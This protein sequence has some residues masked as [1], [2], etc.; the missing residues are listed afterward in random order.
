MSTRRSGLGRGLDAL[1]PS[2]Q[3]DEEGG[4]E[5]LLRVPVDAI[6]PNPRQP[7]QDFDEDEIDELATSISTLGIL[8]PLLVR[9]GG[10][11]RFELIAGER[12]LRASKLAGLSE[13]PVL[14]VETDERGS[15]ERAIVENVHR[16][17]LSP[18]EEAAGYKQLIDEGGM[19]QEQL[20]ERLG[21]N[22]VTVTNTL[23]LLDLP[24]S[25][26]AL[27][28]HRKLTAG[29]GKAL[30]SLQGNPLQE[31]LARRAAEEG[32]SVRD[33]EELARKFESMGAP[34]S[35]S[36]QRVVT[37]ASVSD[38]Q[39]RL[40]DYLQT[41][42]RIDVGKRKGKIVVD[43]VSLEELERVMQTIL[44]EQAGGMPRTASLD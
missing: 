5:G 20:A 11:G 18:I 34:S 41:R 3:P 19:T 36:E 17:N 25:V 9:D 13:V 35:R 14:V 40:A 38:A 39:R 1:L 12:R 32:M 6:S 43:F 22:R 29:H 2:S 26:Q 44:G 24:T 8:Q 37:P 33:T 31:R 15:L 7:R 4:G 10:G 27:L 42:V 16:S 30:L 21:K 23:R 28:A